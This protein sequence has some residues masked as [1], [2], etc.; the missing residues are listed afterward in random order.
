MA[1]TCRK[2][3]RIWATEYSEFDGIVCRRLPLNM[4]SCRVPRTGPVNPN[5]TSRR[6]NSRL[7]S[8]RQAGMTRFVQIDTGK[9]WKPMSEAKANQHPILQ[10]R[11]QLCLAIAKRPAK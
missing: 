5:A 7:L 4:K 1:V 10:H 6:T 9:H 2:R 3:K 11:T 8:D